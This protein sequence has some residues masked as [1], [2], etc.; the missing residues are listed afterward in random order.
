MKSIK[1]ALVFAAEMLLVT[2]A[3]KPVLAAAVADGPMPYPH[4]AAVADGPMPYPH[5]TAY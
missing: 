2:P 3:M 5:Q 1:L 4:V